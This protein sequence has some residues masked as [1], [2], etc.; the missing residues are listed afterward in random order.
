M[1]PRARSP[2]RAAAP[3]APSIVLISVP[4]DVVLGVRLL[5][6]LQGGL[7]DV[8]NIKELLTS[9]SVSV[10]IRQLQPVF[11]GFLGYLQSL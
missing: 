5:E 1:P 7:A 2:R 4:P 10:A 9:P 8:V 11:E 3:A 6:K